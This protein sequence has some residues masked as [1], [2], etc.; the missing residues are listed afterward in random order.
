MCFK[1]LNK[2]TCFTST[3]SL[4]ANFEGKGEKI[5]KFSPF[6]FS[7]RFVSDIHQ[8]PVRP[9]FLKDALPR[10][11]PQIRRTFR[12]SCRRRKP[13]GSRRY[14]P[15]LSFEKDPQRKFSRNKEIKMDGGVG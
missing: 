14:H 8:L 9:Q 11:T 12:I 2:V 4:N 3:I 5:P 13:N 10:Q 1:L 15:S 6:I 7:I